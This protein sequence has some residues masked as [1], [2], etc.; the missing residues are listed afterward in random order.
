[1]VFLHMRLK[2]TEPQ[3]SCRGEHEKAA[4]ALFRKTLPQRNFYGMGVYSIS[5]KADNRVLIW[6]VSAVE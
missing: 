1:M 5:R 2:S 6:P 3:R 4:A